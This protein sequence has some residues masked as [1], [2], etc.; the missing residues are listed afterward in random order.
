MRGWDKGRERSQSAGP[1]SPRG[2]GGLL[3]PLSKFKWPSTGKLGILIRNG[4]VG[5][6]QGPVVLVLLHQTEMIKYIYYYV[7]LQMERTH[8]LFPHF[9]LRT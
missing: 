2:V 6:E 7:L 4:T 9:Q 8:Q 3:H 5:T 1:P